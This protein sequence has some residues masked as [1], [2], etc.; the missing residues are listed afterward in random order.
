MFQNPW[1]LP[2]TDICLTISESLSYDLLY[3][4]WFGIRQGV[5]FSPKFGKYSY[6][7]IKMSQTH[8]NKLQGTFVANSWSKMILIKKILDFYFWKKSHIFHKIDYFRE[9]IHQLQ[10]L[11]PQKYFKIWHV[12]CIHVHVNAV[13]IYTLGCL[14]FL[15][16]WHEVYIC[17]ASS[18]AGFYFL[19][20]FQR[21]KAFY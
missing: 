19:R 2:T 21:M 18:K 12:I 8:F 4:L 13:R 17:I 1:N 5:T 7:F 6:Y 3:D 15:I 14:K 9:T 20:R 10:V 11:V 16:L